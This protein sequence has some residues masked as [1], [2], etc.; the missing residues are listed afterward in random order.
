M[1]QQVSDFLKSITEA[2]QRI[3]GEW[4]KS[5]QSNKLMGGDVAEKLYQ[6]NLDVTEKLIHDTLQAEAAWLDQWQAG[7]ARTP[8]A[9]PAMLELVSGVHATMKAMLQ[10]RAQMWEAWLKQ[11]RS[12]NFEQ[13]PSVVIGDDTQKTLMRVWEEFYQKASE[14]QKKMM[15]QMTPA[16]GS[17]GKRR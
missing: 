3:W 2:N 6:Q 11:A 9:P 15:D 5:L 14:V 8:N 12:M 16:K 1:A 10:H 13:M 17:S 4:A 7:L